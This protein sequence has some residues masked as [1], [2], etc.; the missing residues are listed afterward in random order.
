VSVTLAGAPV[1]VLGAVL[2]SYPA[3]Y[4]VAIQVPRAMADGDFAI[5][6]S[7]NGV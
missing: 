7:V 4:Q 6:A 2:S 5:I 3:V 1:P